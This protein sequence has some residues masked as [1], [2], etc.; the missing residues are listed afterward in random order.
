MHTSSFFRSAC[1]AG[2]LSLLLSV[3]A[4]A[5]PFNIVLN[6]L[7]GLS[8]TQQAIMTT[9]ASTWTALLPGYQP[10]VN[11]PSLT[12]TAQGS[13]IDGVGGVL[14]SA[15]PDVLGLTNQAGFWF[16][17]TGSMNFDTADLADLE[18]SNTLLP[19]VLHEMAH[20]MGFGTLWQLNNVYAP[21]L[22]PGQYTG[23]NG[24]AAYQAEFNQPGALF[25]PVELGGG[26]GTANGH[27]DE[28]D[29]GAGPTGIVSIQGDKQFE[30]M[31]GWLN[32]PYY[33]SNTTIA[34]FV[35]IGYQAAPVP[36]PGTMALFG[37]GIVLIALTRRR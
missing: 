37:A 14:G 22:N 24:V 1:R 9:A 19:V 5:A 11:I 3:A 32:S 20:V 4:A 31:T 15:G 7:G 26:F 18:A 34:S 28:V 25:V 21:I 16:S 23:A 17:T 33:I 8:P 10:G 29:L 2:S 27:W 30:L 35:D 6:F 36:E 12:I 13:L